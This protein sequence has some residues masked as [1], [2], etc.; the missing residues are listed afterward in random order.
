[1]INNNRI[2]RAWYL[3]EVP[4]EH[5][6]PEEDWNLPCKDYYKLGCFCMTK[7]RLEELSSR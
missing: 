6:S 1:M 5:T 7:M 4:G 2:I 3:P